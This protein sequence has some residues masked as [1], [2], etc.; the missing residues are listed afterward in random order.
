MD[1]II[2]D[3]SM[4]SKGTNPQPF[5]TQLKIE[6]KLAACPRKPCGS[7]H[8]YLPGSHVLSF[9]KALLAVI[10]TASCKGAAVLGSH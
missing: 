10:F 7:S 9:G 2:G 8:Q 1:T 5:T 6:T 3:S 4:T